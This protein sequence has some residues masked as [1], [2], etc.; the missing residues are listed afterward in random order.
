[1]ILICRDCHKQVPFGKDC[2]CGGTVELAKTQMDEL[3]LRAWKYQRL[4]TLY[5]KCGPD[6]VPEE[7]I[8][9]STVSLGTPV[10]ADASGAI[11]GEELAPLTPLGV[12]R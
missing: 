10:D 8:Q 3:L 1:M 9:V 5:K 12:V 4:E 6:F 7:A 2:P 11:C